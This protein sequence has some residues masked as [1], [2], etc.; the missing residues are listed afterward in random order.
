M[1]FLS[2]TTLLIVCFAVIAGFFALTATLGTRRFKI[3]DY[4]KF[5]YLF[6]P[7]VGVALVLA[8]IGILDI[9][10][11]PYAGYEVS[12]DYKIIRVDPNSPAARA[13]LKQGDLIVALG[14]VRTNNLYDLSKQPRAEIGDNIR[15]NVL[16]GEASYDFLV[17][18]EPLPG[19][20]V[21]LTWAGN[22]MAFVMLALG[23]A[24]YWRLPSKVSSLFFLGNFC[25]AMAFMTPPYL[26]SFYLRSFVAMSI[27]VFVTMGLAFFLHLAVVFPRP[28]RL[29]TE[30]AFWELIIYVPAPLIAINYLGLRLL[31]PRADLLVNRVLHDAFGLLVFAS[32]V[33][34]LA[35]IA[36][37]FETAIGSELSKAMTWVFAGSLIGILLPTVAFLLHTFEP[38]FVLPGQAYYFLLA[39]L[40]PLSFGAAIWRYG[41]RDPHTE[42][43]PMAPPAARG[44]KA[45]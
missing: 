6:G 28:K 39:I 37:S 19:K 12:P 42:A 7:M 29:I 41:R 36:H 13:G 25:V 16:R 35:A 38:E 44:A 34:A 27:I 5:R 32:L 22:L 3:K 8:L 11:T 31:Q 26:E 21:F 23:L 9:S 45:G 18:P 43:E 1:K 10:S 33:L 20:E 2:T 40:V 30:G 4:V 24:V 15:V 17:K 14:Q